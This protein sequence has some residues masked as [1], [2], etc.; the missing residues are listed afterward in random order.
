MKKSNYIWIP[1]LIILII[2]I[3]HYRKSFDTDNTVAIIMFSALGI[4]ATQKFI[5]TLFYINNLTSSKSESLIVA[6]QIIL[7]HG[8]PSSFTMSILL[9]S[10]IKN[11]VDSNSDLAWSIQFT[12]AILIAVLIGTIATGIFLLKINKHFT[13]KFQEFLKWSIK[14]FTFI[15]LTFGVASLISRKFDPDAIYDMYYQ[16][17]IIIFAT[18]E[19]FE[20]LLSAFDK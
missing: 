6:T 13:M 3:C 16:I 19:F 14:D 18:G 5:Y 11:H 9:T 20:I 10:I 12:V 17:P 7:I 15:S 8:F 4:F 1:W 2:T